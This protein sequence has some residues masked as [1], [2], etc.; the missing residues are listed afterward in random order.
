MQIPRREFERRRAMAKHATPATRRD[1]ADGASGRQQRTRKGDIGVFV[2]PGHEGPI[3]IPFGVEPPGGIG[4]HAG[5]GAGVGADA[6]KLDAPWRRS[7]SAAWETPRAKGPGLLAG[8]R[9][10]EVPRPVLV[11][12]VALVVLAV[13]V[14][15]VLRAQLCAGG[16]VIPRGKDG[17]AAGQASGL[18]AGSGSSAAAPGASGGS[19]GNGNTRDDATGAG[20]GG[21]GGAQEDTPGEN[22]G[23]SGGTAPVGDG[24]AGNGQLGSEGGG[25]ASAG[26]GQVATGSGASA[27]SVPVLVEGG[28]AAGG[29]TEEP[30]GPRIAVHVAGA[31]ARPGVYEL[32]EEARIQDAIDAAGGA[33]PD[34]DVEQLN[35]AERLADGMKVRVPYVGEQAEVTGGGATLSDTSATGQAPEPAT[36]ALVNINTADAALLDTLPGIGPSTAQAIIDERASGGPFTTPEDLMRVSGIGEKKFAKLLGLICV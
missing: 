35:L 8:L 23:T 21:S 10:A 22:G 13:A 4:I 36:P 15:L 6:S 18:N 5:K 2:P 33:L 17:V 32:P 11:A 3:D 16:V 19:A 25:T 1:R 27:T 20:R 31:V 9:V 26:I 29:T 28:G 12:L 14:G 30:A 7:E 34:A 24:A